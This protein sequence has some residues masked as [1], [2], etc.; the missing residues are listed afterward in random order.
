MSDDDIELL[1]NYVTTGFSGLVNEDI[2]E[3]DYDEFLVEDSKVHYFGDF[4]YNGSEDVIKKLKYAYDVKSDDEYDL[5]EVATKRIISNIDFSVENPTYG[6]DNDG[7][8]D[9]VTNQIVNTKR[10]NIDFFLKN[11]VKYSKEWLEEIKYLDYIVLSYLSQMI[12]SNAICSINYVT[13]EHK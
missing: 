12:P 4:L 6:Q 3:K 1:N 11:E 13:K 10:I 2:C 9:G 7:D 5:T 8:L